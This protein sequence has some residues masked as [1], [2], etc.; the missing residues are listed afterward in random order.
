MSGAGE[1]SGGECCYYS[2]LGL[3]NQASGDEIRGAYRKL[4][5]VRFRA[6]PFGNNLCFSFIGFCNFPLC[7]NG[8]PIGG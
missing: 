2:V 7:R 6:F 3:C 4:A 1:N 5:M 8:I